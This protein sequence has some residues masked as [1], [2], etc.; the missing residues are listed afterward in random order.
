M[1]FGRNYVTPFA[2]VDGF[3][4]R[5]G[6][7]AEKSHGVNGGPGILGLAFNSDSVTS[8]ESS[9]G[10]QFNTQIGLA[11]DRLLTPFVR[12]A[13]VHEFNPDRIVGA[14]LIL[15]P[16]AALTLNGA[17][18]AEDAARID[19]GLKLDLS[20]RIALFGLFEGEFSRRSQG[21]AGIGGGDG[22][23]YGSGQGQYYAGH[24]GMRVA[25]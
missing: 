6:N 1:E 11:N 4:L 19:A 12:A 15:S 20:E 22:A 23:F 14:S 2:G 18:A 21:Y 5:S 8:L 10:I 24:F 13:W 16:A 17:S 7:F 25:W 9:V 3:N